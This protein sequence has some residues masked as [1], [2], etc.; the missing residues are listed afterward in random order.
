MLG[1]T[2]TKFL[3]VEPYITVNAGTGD[4]WSARELVEYLRTATEVMAD[5]L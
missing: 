2:L 1:V 3:G 5:S 4:D